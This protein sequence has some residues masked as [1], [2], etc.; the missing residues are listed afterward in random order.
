VHEVEESS[1]STEESTMESAANAKF[2][3]SRAAGEAMTSQITKKL[4][5]IVLLSR[6]VF[7]RRSFSIT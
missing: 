7:L 4:S 2:F 1:F 6:Q 5:K 3:G